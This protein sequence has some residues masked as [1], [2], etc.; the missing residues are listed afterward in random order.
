VSVKNVRVDL[1][2]LTDFCVKALVKKDV[3]EKDARV[4]ADVLVSCDARGVQSHGVVALPGY[5]GQLEAGG[6]KSRP[7]MKVLR[8]SDAAVLIDADA[9]L[10][11]LTG[12]RAMEMAVDKARR[13]GSTTVVVGNSNHFGS[14][15]S[16]AQIAA[17][18]DMLAMVMSNS[19][20][21]MTVAGAV[22]K[23]IGNNPLCLAA[24][25]GR[26]PPVILDMAMS[27]VAY[28]KVLNYELAGKAVPEG[29]LL[30]REGRPT[31]DPTE[32]RNGASLIP[33]G[34]YKGSGLAF[35]VEVLTGVLSGS[36]ITGELRSWRRQ[37]D[38]HPRISHT[39]QAVSIE[40]LMPVETFKSR[41][42]G[43]I[44]EI[45]SAPK[46][47]GVDR[48]YVPGEIEQECWERS[49][50]E[51]VELAPATYDRLT[52]LAGSVGVVLGF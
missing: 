22:G 26:Y 21:C 36:G 34:G 35:F 29:W 5:I 9:G 41:I 19:G 12:V 48:I 23:I 17:E 43:L 33:M 3:P 52:E 10:G 30:D 45:K 2:T 31:C 24:P 15:A 13:T 16:F 1:E 32:W 6:V 44:E 50:R 7:R 25:A 37:P 39:F 27:K 46:A 40:I 11:Q 51:G 47:P 4:V 49:K 42:D 8:E 18:Q 28:G 38:Q 14:A 20:R